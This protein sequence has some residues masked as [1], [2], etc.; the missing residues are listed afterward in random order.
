M[1]YGFIL[2]M[3]TILPSGDITSIEISF[4][5][6]ATSETIIRWKYLTITSNGNYSNLFLWNNLLI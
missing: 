4:Y 1:I 6:A 3:V 5:F 2:I